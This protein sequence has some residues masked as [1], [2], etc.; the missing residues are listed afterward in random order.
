MSQISPSL[1]AKG[2]RRAVPPLGHEHSSQLCEGTWH[3]Q[4]AAAQTQAAVS[5]KASFSNACLLSLFSLTQ[6]YK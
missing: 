3:R 1:G 6:V 5:P 2:T 4:D